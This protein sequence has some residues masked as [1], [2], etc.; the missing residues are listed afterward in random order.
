[1]KSWRNISTALGVTA[2]AAVGAG[3]SAGE[4]SRPDAE[5]AAELQSPGE[6]ARDVTS[7]PSIS[8]STSVGGGG[9]RQGETVVISWQGT[10]APAGA[11]VGLWPVKAVTGHV[12]DAIAAG[13]PVTGSHAWR[14]P[15]LK[16]GEPIACARDITGGCVGSMNPGTTYKI[17]ARLYVPADADISQYGPGRIPPGFVA[18][19]ESAAFTMSASEQ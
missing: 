4:G 15:V 12:F 7:S 3:A 8:V 10:H 5:R 17:V 2:L 6:R 13:L 14:V 19:G 16:M 9:V 1:M 11:A 18:I